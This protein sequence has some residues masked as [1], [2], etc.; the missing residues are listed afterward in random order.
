[1]PRVR[2]RDCKQLKGERCEIKM[3]YMNPDTLR[4]CLHYENKDQ[5]PLPIWQSYPGH[6]WPP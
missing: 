5:Q 3:K 4:Y 2:C 6:C 1:M